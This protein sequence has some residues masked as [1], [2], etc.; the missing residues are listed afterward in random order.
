MCSTNFGTPRFR[1]DRVRT[2]EIVSAASL[3]SASASDPSIDRGG[4]FLEVTRRPGVSTMPS[5]G[6]FFLL[7]ETCVSRADAV[8]W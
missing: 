7:G 2:E 4:L 8:S 1:N 3:E 6:S 5:K